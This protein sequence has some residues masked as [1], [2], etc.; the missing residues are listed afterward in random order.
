MPRTLLA[1]VLLA[2]G[3]AVP[4]IAW[5]VVG[6]RVADR[7]AR[8]ALEEPRREAERIAGKLAAQLAERLEALRRS[9][10]DRPFYHY[11]ALYHDPAGA[12]EGPS[13]APS[14]LARGPADP[15][16]LAHFEVGRS[17]ALTLPTLGAAPAPAAVVARD[18]AVAQRLEPAVPELLASLPAA[19]SSGRRVETL[20]QSAYAQNLQAPQLY[21]DIKLKQSGKGPGAPPLPADPRPVT[22]ETSR[23]AW[24][25]LAPGG[26]PMLAAVRTVRG[27]DGRRLQGFVVDTAEVARVLELSDLPT[28]F[29]PAAAIPGGIMALVTGTGWA[30]TL[31]ADAPLPA[32]VTR[33]QA[34]R[35]RFHR[36]FAL[37]LLAAVLAGLAVVALVWQSERLARQRAQFAAAAAHELRTPL[38]GLRM[39]GEMLSEGLGAPDRAREYAGTIAAEAERLGRVVA[40]VLGYTRLERGTLRVEPVTGDLAA[41]VGTIVD[42]HRPALERAGA[43]VALVTESGLPAARFDPD[44]LH[45]IV[46]NLLDNAERHT[47][48]ATDRRIEVALRR[49]ASG[50]TLTV[51]DHG[52]GLPGGAPRRAPRSQ[53]AGLGLGLRLV[54]ALARAQGGAVSYDGAPGAGARVSVTFP[55]A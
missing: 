46:H 27:P 41:V 31:A 26:A 45:Q 19:E 28:R 36:G 2:I 13:V 3:L 11:Q 32:A 50:V 37:G 55:A 7:E 12:S 53:T 54:E 25:T 35:G 18:R 8:L 6:R 20:A 34:I 42:R 10:S 14:P 29:A 49:A 43:A 24:T 5:Y 23:L 21:R 15:L 51:G 17:G 39:Y 38:A 9:E 4:S 22:V 40:N 48:D 33:A 44:A 52:P 30:V 47:R 1:V 16:V